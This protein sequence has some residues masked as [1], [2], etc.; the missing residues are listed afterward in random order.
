MSEDASEDDGDEDDDPDFGSSTKRKPSK[1]KAAK[2]SVFN[3][4]QC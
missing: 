2:K 4:D 1:P 3:A